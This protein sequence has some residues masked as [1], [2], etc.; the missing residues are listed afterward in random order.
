MPRTEPRTRARRT[1]GFTLLEIMVAL[2]VSAA[3]IGGAHALF[4]LLADLSALVGDVRDDGARR[5]NG[6]RLLR[7]LLLSAEAGADPTATFAG[8]SQDA[9]FDSWCLTSRGWSERCFATLR[10][11][12]DPQ[13][14]DTSDVLAA[15]S[16]GEQLSLW[17]ASA[18]ATLGYLEDE[19]FGGTWMPSWGP[20]VR[21]PLALGILSPR[22]TIVL[23]VGVAR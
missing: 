12:V 11:V 16:T 5:S 7:D 3:A 4:G 2:V 1:R 15:L 10:L 20:G 19:S 18:Q 21:A 14:P 6:E 23:R 8:T 13:Q 22:D 17:R 9:R